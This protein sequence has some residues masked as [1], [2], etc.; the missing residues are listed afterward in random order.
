M[1]SQENCLQEYCAKPAKDLKELCQLHG[2]K[3]YGA[4]KDLLTRLF[5]KLQPK[6]P[7]PG[8]VPGLDLETKSFGA[9]LW[10]SGL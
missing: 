7:K 3:E 4:K 8:P 6:K 10:E 9:K 5:T 1:G 2:L